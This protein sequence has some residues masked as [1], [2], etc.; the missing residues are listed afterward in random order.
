M[1]SCAFVPWR[2]GGSDAAG[3]SGLDGALASAHKRAEIE[4]L[5]DEIGAAQPSASAV[6]KAILRASNGAVDEEHAGRI[7]A[8]VIAL[9]GMAP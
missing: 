8:D 5:L 3:L 7:A 1:P 6:V 2:L 4:R 9:Y